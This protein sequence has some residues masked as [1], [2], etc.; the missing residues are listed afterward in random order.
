MLC[1]FVKAARHILCASVRVLYVYMCVSVYMSLK[2][3]R[4]ANVRL[5]DQGGGKKKDDV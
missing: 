5:K 3:A 1:C 4:D 2:V